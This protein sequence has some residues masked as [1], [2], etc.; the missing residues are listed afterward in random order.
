MREK[1]ES[2]RE[3]RTVNTTTIT[4]NVDFK[5]VSTKKNIKKY[6]YIIKWQI[7]AVKGYSFLKN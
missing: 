2:L 6:V 3:G 7:I 5:F 4:N 1:G